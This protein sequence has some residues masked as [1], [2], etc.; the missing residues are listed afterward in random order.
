MRSW[1][2]TRRMEF[3]AVFAILVSSVLTFL[4]THIT[5]T[6]H[7]S[8]VDWTATSW[9][10][11]LALSAGI[12][13]LETG[14]FMSAP[15]VLLRILA[16][17]RYFLLLIA[18]IVLVPQLGFTKGIAGGITLVLAVSFWLFAMLKLFWP[19]HAPSFPLWSLF[20]WGRGSNF[21]SNTVQ[22]TSSMKEGLH[23]KSPT[24]KF[25]DVGGQDTVKEQIRRLVQTRLQAGKFAKHGIVQNGI[26]L[27]GPQGTGKTLL[28]EATAGEFGLRY[29]YVSDSTERYLAW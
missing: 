7:Q 18:F 25:K 2:L 26:L 14:L 4:Y 9:P 8:A 27:Y 29:L 3:G 1:S 22:G 13:L 24:L 11:L 28:A 20:S 6:N 16:L 15:V 23:T 17:I 19:N 12:H 5:G 21:S 10:T